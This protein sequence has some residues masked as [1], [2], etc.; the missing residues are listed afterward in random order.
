MSF[1]ITVLKVLAGHPEGRACVADVTRCVSILISSG[2]DWTAR[3]KRLAAHAPQLDIFGSAFVLRDESGWQIT[4]IGR[5]FL[6][7]LETASPIH[8]KE[9]QDEIASVRPTLNL[10]QPVLRLVVDNTRSRTDHAPELPRQ[11]A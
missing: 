1:Q 4:D 9:Q 6:D 11:I 10:V 8:C 2:S 5:Q 3:M 7:S